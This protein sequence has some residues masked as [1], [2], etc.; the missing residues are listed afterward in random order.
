MSFPFGARV[1]SVVLGDLITCVKANRRLSDKLRECRLDQFEEDVRLQLPPEELRAFHSIS[2]ERIQRI[3]SK[4]MGTL[5]GVGVAMPVLGAT[6][7]IIGGNGVLG[8]AA[9]VFRISAAVLL[10]LGVLYFLT[11]GWLALCCYRVR[12]VYRPDMPDT[13]P[14]AGPRHLA[15]VLLFST[16]QNNRIAI[17]RANWLETAFSQ[18]RNG[19]V[20]VGLLT[21]L[22]VVSS[23]I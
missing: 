3:E 8:Q 7:G 9:P 14:N 5:V 11:S 20:A 4:A 12:E 17:M 21:V 22:V 18:L 13:V 1:D 19:L 15:K 2:L 6:S 23:V 16:E 10:L